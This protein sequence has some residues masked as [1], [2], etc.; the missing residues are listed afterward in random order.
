MR[1]SNIS[2]RRVAC[3]LL[4]A[5]ISFLK[6][7][8]SFGC[9]LFAN[10]LQTSEMSSQKVVYPEDEEP[11]KSNEL[12][13]RIVLIIGGHGSGKS[14]LA[15][16]IAGKE[17]LFG[18]QYSRSASALTKTEART[19]AI[20]FGDE[21][22]V[23]KIIEFPVLEDALLRQDHTTIS[24]HIGDVTYHCAGTIH[25]LLLV[26]RGRFDKRDSDEFDL[27]KRALFSEN[28][29]LEHTTV[30]QTGFSEFRNERATKEALQLL[31]SLSECLVGNIDQGR[32]L[33]VDNTPATSAKYRAPAHADR[34]ASRTRL[35]QHLIDQCRNPFSSDL[36]KD[37]YS[38]AAKLRKDQEGLEAAIQME[39]DNLIGLRIHLGDKGQSPPD[40]SNQSAAAPGIAGDAPQQSS[41]ALADSPEAGPDYANFAAG[42][43]D[44]L[45]QIRRDIADLKKEVAEIR[46]ILLSIPALK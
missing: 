25:Q 32:F 6:H 45:Q 41:L 34:L 40:W 26:T 44:S 27:L 24:G 8:P 39:R 28:V 36:M 10:F 31:R 23:L 13:D 5:V 3:S 29:V 9:H 33:A 4:N 14:A 22:Y 46:R 19:V 43:Q 1:Y 17:D 21:R 7:T 15:N 37:L 30:I 18:E 11:P 16:V 35:L 38:S 42:I 12:P 2:W 20:K